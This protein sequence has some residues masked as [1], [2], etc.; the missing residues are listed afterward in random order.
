MKMLMVLHRFFI[1]L[2]LQIALKAWY[3]GLFWS[4]TCIFFLLTIY[5]A[6][7]ITGIQNVPGKTLTTIRN[8]IPGLTQV[9]IKILQYP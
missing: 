8:I 1:N 4:S 9:I 2:Y 5:K 3:S 7:T 6:L